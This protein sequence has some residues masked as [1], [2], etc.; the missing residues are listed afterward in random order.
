MQKAKMDRI[1]EETDKST[2]IMK[3]FNTSFL[4]LDKTSRQKSPI[5]TY[6]IRTINKLD[7][8]DMYRTRN[9]KPYSTHSFQAHT[10]HLQKLT[11]YCALKQ[12]Q[13]TFKNWNLY[14]V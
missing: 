6:K 1:E 13:Q 3:D 2:V 11:M 7:I 9:A 4:G 12:F 10:G 5:R 8:I 14:K